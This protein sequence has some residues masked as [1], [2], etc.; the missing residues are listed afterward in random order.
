MKN[1]IVKQIKYEEN[2]KSPLISQLKKTNEQIEEHYYNIYKN[3]VLKALCFDS[4]I[5]KIVGMNK[6][7]NTLEELKRFRDENTIYQSNKVRRI[8]ARA[9]SY[10]EHL[11]I[12]KCRYLESSNKTFAEC[13]L[14]EDVW[15][16][17]IFSE[18]DYTISTCKVF[19][20][21]F[22]QIQSII[23]LLEEICYNSFNEPYGNG[24]ANDMKRNVSD[25]IPKPMSRKDKENLSWIMQQ[26]KELSKLIFDNTINFVDCALHDVD[27]KGSLKSKK[28]KCEQALNLIDYAIG[29]M[30]KDLENQFLMRMYIDE[31]YNDISAN[32]EFLMPT[33][34][35][36]N[37]KM[38][39]AYT[40]KISCLNLSNAATIAI[41]DKKSDIYKV[42]KSELSQEAISKI[43]IK[44]FP[45]I[46]LCIVED[47]NHR[48][49]REII[50]HNHMVKAETYDLTKLFD[51]IDVDEFHMQWL[52]HDESGTINQKLAIPDIR[53]AL[54]FSLGKKKLKILEKYEKLKMCKD[55]E[56]LN[57]V[58]KAE[59]RALERI[60]AE[61][62]YSILSYIKQKHTGE[63]INVSDISL[64]LL[65]PIEFV[66]RAINSEAGKKII[67]KKL[68][69]AC[70][71]TDKKLIYDNLDNV[72][73]NLFQV[74]CCENQCPFPDCK[75]Q[76]SVQYVRI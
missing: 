72:P 6:I 46:N 29:L 13:L 52:I 18:L 57:E 12:M 61:E 41:P 53:L 36:L 1:R 32:V 69:L 19:F 10:I 4:F 5:P 59:K 50:N 38:K 65:L 74:F 49:A 11:L 7:K 33:Y 27:K 28:E 22:I 8:P 23:D 54:L 39:S 64:K 14:R 15:E 71:Y 70:P 31:Y 68:V 3:R 51:Y 24:C 9:F 60:Y 73:E 21:E 55:N 45:L 76:L 75:K 16:E 63:I 67:G 34:V 35:Y 40:G 25:F 56:G 42:C 43:K 30:G 58:K 48:T 62:E 2:F 26:E 37:N 66:K 17:D 20:S 44:Y 47:G